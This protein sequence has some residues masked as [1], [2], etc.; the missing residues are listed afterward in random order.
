MM[1][2]KTQFRNFPDR[3]LTF[4]K[5]NEHDRGSPKIKRCLRENRLQN[6]SGVTPSGN[7]TFRRI[8]NQSARNSLHC[9]TLKTHHAYDPFLGHSCLQ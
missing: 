3:K 7:R 6:L 1:L 4:N 2:R 9:V 8:K 5:P